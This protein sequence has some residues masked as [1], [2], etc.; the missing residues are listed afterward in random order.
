MLSIEIESSFIL[1]EN[2]TSKNRIPGI[3]LICSPRYMR[4]WMFHL[5]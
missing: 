1:P 5:L 4:V 2:T 3:I